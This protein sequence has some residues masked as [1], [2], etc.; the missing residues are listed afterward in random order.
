MDQIYG[1]HVT[2]TRDLLN[3]GVAVN[4]TSEKFGKTPLEYAVEKADE[5]F[6]D[7]ND[8]CTEIIR[9]LLNRGA[10]PTPTDALY[11]LPYIVKRKE[12]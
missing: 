12:S 3:R 10:N 1:C 7:A 6:N 5:T 8:R 9:L 2:Q 4:V 11:P